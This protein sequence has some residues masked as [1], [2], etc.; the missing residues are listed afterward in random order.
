V[1]EVMRCL[2]RG[3]KESPIMPLKETLETMKLWM[4]CD[5]NGVSYIMVNNPDDDWK[6]YHNVLN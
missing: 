5:W 2:D 6:I 1:E 3:L 4:D